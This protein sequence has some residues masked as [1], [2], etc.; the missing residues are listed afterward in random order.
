MKK[1]ITAFL[2]LMLA[3]RLAAQTEEGVM[4]RGKVMYKNV[5]VANENVININSE[6]ATITNDEGEFGIFVKP[7]DELVFSAVN[8]KLKTVKIT[9][10]IIQNRRLVVA[11]DEKVTELDEVIVTPENR[12][13]FAELREEEFKKFDYDRDASTPVVNEALSQSERGM[14]YGIN[15]VSIFK[16]LFRSKAGK[17][18]I[19]GG[20]VKPS[21]VLRQLYEDEFFVTDLKIPHDKID[22]FLYYC[23]DQLPTSSLMKKENEFQLVDFLVTQSKA[24]RKTLE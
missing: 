9:E 12:E 23:D 2:F 17:N 22:A 21:D 19:P 13:K 5:N 24:Y 20:G 10:E 7:G 18:K 15:F 1:H 4:L 14:Q 16:A 3:M 11:V 6:E 8:Y